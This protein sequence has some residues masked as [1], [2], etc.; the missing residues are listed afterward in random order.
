[1]EVLLLW[2]WL[3]VCRES[4]SGVR[5]AKSQR[6]QVTPTTPTAT[7]PSPSPCLPTTPPTLSSFLITYVSTLLALPPHT[8]YISLLFLSLSL[9]LSVSHSLYILPIRI[10]I[11]VQNSIPII[12]NSSVFGA[13]HVLK[14]TTPILVYRHP[15]RS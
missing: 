11:P 15:C 9:S 6:A 13:P 5:A 12:Q 4:G 1:M 3:W 14:L 10:L 8:A 7:A 2:I